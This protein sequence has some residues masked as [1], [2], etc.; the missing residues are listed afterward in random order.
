MTCDDLP[1]DENRIEVDPTR[2]DRWGMPLPRMV[3]RLGDNTRA[4]RD[5]GVARALEALRAA[6]A[7][8][9]VVT[10]ISSAAGFHL[11][12]TARMGH[13]HRTSVTDRDGRMHGVENL[14]IADSALFASAA[15]VNPTSTLQAVALRAADAMR[16]RLGLGEVLT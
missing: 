15:A 6:G 1:E 5:F 14:T 12:G 13:D 7:W 16:R 8:K 11:M 2:H 10:R 3:Y 9:I 4:M